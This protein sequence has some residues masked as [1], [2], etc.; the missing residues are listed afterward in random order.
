MRIDICNKIPANLPLQPPEVEP[1]SVAP[2]DAEGSDEPAGSVFATTTT[3]S[4]SDQPTLV[5]PLNF[6]KPKLKLK[7]THVNHL[8]PNQNHPQNYLNQMY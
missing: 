5:K 7:L 6:A 8:T 3:S 1:L 2:A 4:Q